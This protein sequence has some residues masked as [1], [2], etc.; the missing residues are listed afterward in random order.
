MGLNSYR[1]R[2]LFKN[3]MLPLIFS[4][5]S[6]ALSPEI[7]FHDHNRGQ[8]LIFLFSGKSNALDFIRFLAHLNIKH[9]LVSL[10]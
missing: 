2:Y 6:G 4:Q 1:N 5:S 9:Y 3:A 8:V 10:S 7:A